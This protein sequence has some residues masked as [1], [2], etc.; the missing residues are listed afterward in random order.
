MSLES[1][2]IGNAVSGFFLRMISPDSRSPTRYASALI[3]GRIASLLMRYDGP[4]VSSSTRSS[5]GVGSLVAIGSACRLKSDAADVPSE[6][7]IDAMPMPTTI[8][9]AA[10]KYCLIVPLDEG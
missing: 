5:S 6:S 2:A 3:L 1:D 9:S 4:A 10:Q 7:S 8:E